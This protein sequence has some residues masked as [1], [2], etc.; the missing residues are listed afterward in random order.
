[1]AKNYD[2]CIDWF[3][4]Q[5]SAGEINKNNQEE[6]FEALFAEGSDELC[7]YAV[8][9]HVKTVLLAKLSLL[10]VRGPAQYPPFDLMR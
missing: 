9:K 6:L 10:Y 7:K 2:S 5:D 8:S 4:A 1:M 3:D